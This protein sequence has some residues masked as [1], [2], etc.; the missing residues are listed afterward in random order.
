MKFSYQARTKEG[1]LKKGIVEATS[2]QAA[3]DTLQKYGFFATYLSRIENKCVLHKQVGSLMGISKKDVAVFTRQLAIMYKSQVPV[4]ESLTAISKQ[5]AK[6]E[7]KEKIYKL[8]QSV[9]GGATLS[10]ACALFPKVFS[11]FF[12]NMVKAGEASGK[13]S[14]ALEYLAKH[15]EQEY[16]FENKLKSAMIYPIMVLVIFSAV[17]ILMMFFIMPP[18]VGILKES[19]VELPLVTKIAIGASD[20]FRQWFILLFLG[21]AGFVAFVIN[22]LRTPEGKA[23]FEKNILKVPI[24]GPLLKKVY[25]TRFAENLSTLITGGLPIAQALEI[26]GDVVGNSVYKK[27]IFDVEESVRRG[28]TISATLEK[29]PEEVSSLF[30]QMALV[31]E[32]TGRLENSFENIVTFYSKEVER[33]IDNLISLLEPAMIIVLAILIGGLMGAVLLPMYQMGGTI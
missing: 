25:L 19:E 24:V 14:E 15:L 13:L 30:V 23:L 5:T 18:I 21:L 20:F 1:L 6:E 31:G 12:V 26:T 28:E 11:P 17:F 9:E 29:Y 33:G 8:S 2:E 10:A 32:K 22:Y 3:L 27:I 16:E 7:F 4:V